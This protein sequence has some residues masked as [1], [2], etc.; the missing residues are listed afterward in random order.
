MRWPPVSLSSKTSLPHF[1]LDHALEL[2]ELNID[3]LRWHEMLQPFGNANPQPIFFA[4]EVMP[5]APPRVVNDK[6]LLLNL[7]Q[8]DARRR[9]VFFDGAAQPLPSPPWDIAFRIR[10]DD[11]DGERLVGMQI[12]AL[13]S[14][15]SIS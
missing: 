15:C 2:A 4:R 5:A 1:Q 8:G 14:A 6:H 10:P 3:F 7:R 12:H 9:A 13:R 11:Y